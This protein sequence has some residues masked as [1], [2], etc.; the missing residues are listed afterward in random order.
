M[1][2]YQQFAKICHEYIETEFNFDAMCKKQNVYKMIRKD[3]E[4]ITHPAGEGLDLLELFRTFKKYD[5]NM[6]GLLEFSEYTQ[7]LS[8]S[9]HLD[10]NKNEIVTLAMVA[11]INNDGQ[12]DFEE[13]TKHYVDFLDM[14]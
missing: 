9:P 1:V 8:E 4:V 7:C 10:L 14:I 6:N 3:D 11:D 5:R 12:I 13:F 2:P